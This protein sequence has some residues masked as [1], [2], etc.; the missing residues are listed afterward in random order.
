M[1]LILLSLKLKWILNDS[2]IFTVEVSTIELSLHFIYISAQTYFTVFSLAFS[3]DRQ[4]RFCYVHGHAGISGNERPH[5]Q[6]EAAAA[7]L[8]PAYVLPSPPIW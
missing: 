3:K 5:D 8:A 6:I 2:S 1:S 7:R 4:V